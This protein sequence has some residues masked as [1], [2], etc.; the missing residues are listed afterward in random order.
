MPG[1][2]SILSKGAF[3]FLDSHPFVQPQPIWAEILTGE[4]WY[5]NGC[6]GYAH[7]KNSLNELEI[8]SETELQSPT[9]LL[10]DAQDGTIN[11]VINVPL[12]LPRNSSRIWLSDGSLPIFASVQPPFIAQQE[13]FQ[14]YKPRPTT[15]ISQT[16]NE[17]RSAVRSLLNVELHR[18][19]CALNLAFT[20]NWQMLLYRATIFDQ[21]SHIFGT[22]YLHGELSLNG[23]LIAFLEEFDNRLCALI[24][25]HPLMLLSSFSHVQCRALLSINDW[26]NDMGYLRMVSTNR[27]QRQTALTN[28]RS[29]QPVHA[30]ALVSDSPHFDT[31]ITTCASVQAGALYI[32]SIERFETGI[33]SN[34]DKASKRQEIYDRLSDKCKDLKDIR[35][36]QNPLNDGKTADILIAADGIEMVDRLS[37]GLQ[38]VHRHSS[39]HSS[40][41]FIWSQTPK[42][43]TVATT[44]V[45]QIAADVISSST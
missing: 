35:I 40:K 24:G 36:I 27:P 20:C 34:I 10:P 2:S 25:P 5:R 37:A 7:P 4:P 31:G 38:N 33:V 16:M 30:S 44:K 19:T 43:Q 13:L 6:V 14:E 22:H 3:S 11:I 9:K 45:F 17:A 28:M 29:N 15:S 18:L 32:N 23:E 42:Q 12:L 41:G 8:F 39:T 26:L 21:L 1:L